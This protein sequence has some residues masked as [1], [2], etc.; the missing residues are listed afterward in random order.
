MSLIE[1]N[2]KKYLRGR[3]LPSD[4][5]EQI[6]IKAVDDCGTDQNCL[7]DVYNTESAKGIADYFHLTSKN[8]IGKVSGYTYYLHDFNGLY[9][10]NASEYE[11]GVSNFNL[12][13]DEND[14]IIVYVYLVPTSLNINILKLIGLDIADAEPDEEYNDKPSITF[15]FGDLTVYGGVRDS[16]DL[17]LANQLG[18]TYDRLNMLHH[19]LHIKSY[20]LPEDDSKVA[21]I[22]TEVCSFLAINYELEIFNEVIMLSG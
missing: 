7:I 17:D 20:K 12:V 13:L 8:I 10:A 6:H 11:N 19:I 5:W 3:N 15:E 14:E 22:Y 9:S 4:V 18:I 16:P 2:V 1:G 21:L